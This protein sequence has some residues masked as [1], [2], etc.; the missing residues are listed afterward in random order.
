MNYYKRHLGDYAKDTRH[1]SLAEHGAYCLL[2]D[3]YYSTER[4]IPDDRC[5][6]IANAYADDERMA[7]RNVL[8]AF[9]TLTDEGWRNARA[10]AEI[11]EF[12]GKSL[13][14]KEAANARWSGRNADA[15]ANA[16]ETHGDPHSGRNAS[17]KPLAISHKESK[18]DKSSLSPAGVPDC[19]HA[20]IL[21]LYHEMLPANPRMKVWN[22]DRA[23]SLRAR[24]REDQK[25]QSLDY[26]RRFF[27]KVAKSP[28]LTGQVD[29]R[30]SRP[31]LPG[32][33][34]MV[35]ASNFAKIIEGRYDGGASA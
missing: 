6:R 31:F 34:W 35:K 24:W 20:E 10:D 30:N 3:Y 5:E 15:Y 19:P 7:V 13:K 28:F 22:G 32:L 27:A 26:W 29:G 21:A 23:A 11:D 8:A 14:A 12:H 17:H 16:S 33:D 4:P 2:L 1:L 9:F 18:E 25:R